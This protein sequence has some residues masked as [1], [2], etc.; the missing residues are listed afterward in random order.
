MD[1][2]SCADLNW[3][4]DENVFGCALLAS[5]YSSL[6]FSGQKKEKRIALFG[7]ESYAGMS[8]FW[9]IKWR[10]IRRS[11]HHHGVISL[12]CCTSFKAFSYFLFSFYFWQII[13]LYVFH[14][15]FL[16]IF[17]IAWGFQNLH[18]DP[19][20]SRSYT[21]I[22]TLWFENANCWWS[23]AVSQSVDLCVCQNI[24]WLTE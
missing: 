5:T 3:K 22:C 23:S 21:H 12:P 11:N 24:G 15:G 6:P 1:P 19:R 4:N 20:T 18:G 16:S 13:V 14:S 9:G 17:I 8:R 10:F 7:R 2:P